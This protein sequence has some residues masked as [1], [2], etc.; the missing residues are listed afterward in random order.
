MHARER[1][2]TPFGALV[3]DPA[4]RAGVRDSCGRGTLRGT[5]RPPHAAASTD[6]QVRTLSPRLLLTDFVTNCGRRSLTATTVRRHHYAGLHS[7]QLASLLRRSRP[8]RRSE[9]GRRGGAWRC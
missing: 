8:D 7:G 9:A 6:E 4:P 3:S 2:K 1:A 5:D